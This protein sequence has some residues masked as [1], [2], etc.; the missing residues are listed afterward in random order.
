MDRNN[1]RRD[2]H[3]YYRGYCAFS[4]DGFPEK[5]ND[6]FPACLVDLL[7]GKPLSLE[8][9]LTSSRSG[10]KL[11]ML[12]I[13]R[14][15]SMDPYAAYGYLEQYA[16]LI[17]KILTS[18]SITYHEVNDSSSEFRALGIFFETGSIYSSEKAAL[19]VKD[20]LIPSESGLFCYAPGQLADEA[21]HFVKWSELCSILRRHDNAFISVC[22]IHRE[23]SA[24]CRAQIEHYS[25]MLASNLFPPDNAGLSI[26]SRWRSIPDHEICFVSF[27]AAGERS[28]CIE[29]QTLAQNHDL[30]ICRIDDNAFRIETYAHT[31]DTDICAY[32]A[33]YAHISEVYDATRVDANSLSCFGWMNHATNLK[34]AGKLFSFP[35][36]FASLC[37][38]AGSCPDCYS[39]AV[40]D[41][42]TGGGLLVGNTVRFGSPIYLQPDMLTKHCAIVGKSGC[43]KTT[44]AMG[45][46]KSLS[47]KNIPFIVI[48]PVKTEYRALMDLIP[49]LKVYTPCLNHVSPLSLNPFLPPRGVTLSEYL[50]ELQNIFEAS[51]NLNAPLNVLFPKVM[52]ICYSKHKWF[53]DST[54]D[55]DGIQVF[56]MRE[57]I[58]E[59]IKTVQEGGYDEKESK[60]NIISAGVSRLS[61]MLSLDS[62]LFDTECSV[63]YDD[64]LNGHSVI[65][66]NAISNDTYRSIVLNTLMHNLSLAA[67]HKNGQSGL[68]RSVIFIDE[69]HAILDCGDTRSAEG[70]VNTSAANVKLLGDMIRIFRSYGV[71]LIFADQSAMSL[72][73]AIIDQV[74]IRM[75][76]KLDKPNDLAELSGCLGL[77][78]DQ[79]A[80]IRNLPVGQFIL[81]TG[82]NNIPIHIAGR[83]YKK[84]LH[85]RDVVPNEE[86]ASRCGNVC[87]VPYAL[88]R[89]HAHCGSSCDPTMRSR[90]DAIATVL[91]TDPVFRKKLLERINDHCA[92]NDLFKSSLTTNIGKLL[93]EFRCPENACLSDCIRIRLAFMLISDEVLGKNV[94]L[95]DA[96]QLF[97]K[98]TN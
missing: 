8:F 22:F 97:L 6:G 72:S 87:P 37:G 70:A 38:S 77:S 13:L 20:K 54:R 62:V 58:S 56:G 98:G 73:S 40:P 80:A 63:D 21:G 65:E 14:I 12:A 17:G 30:D 23:M 52:G 95:K 35:G 11:S 88:C 29:L 2:N 41:C 71:S 16:Q 27:I 49:G 51:F 75:I 31:G 9:A 90:A 61:S 92:P 48:E 57:F 19:F 25:G 18:Y 46:L 44:F 53:M 86:V 69:A 74:D 68:L 55:S 78:S 10:S 26:F 36:D 76:F 39:Y 96:A 79:I 45:L 93:N 81:S 89:A 34:T 84:E 7:D 5:L 94:C 43:G 64:L 24:D 28:F 3:G 4:I 1:I 85:I 32:L 42:M 82:K 60:T 91:F 66:L 33:K 83:D 50:P 67:K 15:N 47:D 59:F